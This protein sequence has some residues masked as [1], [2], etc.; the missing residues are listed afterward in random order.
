[1][2]IDSQ[3]MIETFWIA[4]SGVPVTLQLTFGSLLIA[5]FPAFFMA[6]GSMNQSRGVQN[7]IRFYVSL[8]RGTPIV[9][10]ILFFYS[11]LPSTLNLLFKSLHFD[12]DVFAVP[13]VLYAYVVFTL[14]TIASLTEVFRS[15]LSTVSK[16]QLEA[17][18]SVGLTQVQAYLRIVIPQAFVVAL[19]NLC[20][21]TVNLL[22]GTSL[23]FLMTVKEVTA[24]AKLEAS[25]GY[26]YIEAYLDIF[27]IYIIMC[28]L[29][30]LLFRSIEKY[31]GIYHK[32]LAT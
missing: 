10:Q 20:N 6:I 22:K 21:V 4:L 31:M 27:I 25:Y 23:A 24:L 26:N 12:I 14:N 32:G 28:T 7:M 18:Q 9:L 29:V 19:P 11:L 1:M 17:A 16:G 8:I 13:P 5:V 30:Q 15:A 3:F 2:K